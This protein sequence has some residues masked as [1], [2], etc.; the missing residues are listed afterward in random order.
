M[1]KMGGTFLRSLYSTL[2]E[3]AE[4]IDEAEIKDLV[5]ADLPPMDMIAIGEMLMDTARCI[6]VCNN[7][8]PEIKE[9][10]VE[11]KLRLVKGGK[12]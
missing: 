1:V 12:T 7:L 4:I 8:P 2:R 9:Y 5:K 11:R 3:N 6:M 10:K